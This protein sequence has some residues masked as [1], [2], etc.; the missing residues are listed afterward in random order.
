M[1][2]AQLQV[3]LPAFTF[4]A[5]VPHAQDSFFSLPH[6]THRFALPHGSCTLNPHLPR[7][8][9]LACPSSPQDREGQD[10]GK[11]KIKIGRIHLSALL[12]HRE[13]WSNVPPP[14]SELGDV[15]EV[16]NTGELLQDSLRFFP[17][18]S[19]LGC[20]RASSPRSSQIDLGVLWFAL[21]LRFDFV[22]LPQSCTLVP[23][24]RP[25]L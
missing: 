15:V 18:R 14:F 12:P 5:P 9:V 25:K 11:L 17:S 13:W 16:E 20:R 21:D 2:P 23:T 3:F 10:T 6:Q 22:Y 4:L 24:R 8:G 19:H 7:S 1:I